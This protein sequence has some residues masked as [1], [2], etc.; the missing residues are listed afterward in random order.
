MQGWGRV[1][2]C[3]EV[4]INSFH[5][6]QDAPASVQSGLG[7]GGVEFWEPLYRDASRIRKHTILGP[8]RSLYL[9]S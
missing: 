1:R 4:K 6:L 2:Q 5:G 9:G 8:Y 3:V 7:G